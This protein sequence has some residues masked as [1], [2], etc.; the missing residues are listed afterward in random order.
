MFHEIFVKKQVNESLKASSELISTHCEK[1]QLPND[2]KNQVN[3]SDL[4]PKNSPLS[5]NFFIYISRSQYHFRL[6]K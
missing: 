6:N 3:S 5:Q 2:L 1:V 4:V